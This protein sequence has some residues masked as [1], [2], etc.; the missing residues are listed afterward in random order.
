MLSKSFLKVM[1][2]VSSS[3]TISP[4]HCSSCFG[5][6]RVLLRQEFECI[7]VAL[8]DQT[9]VFFS[10]YLYHDVSLVPRPYPCFS[11]LHAEK[12]QRVT[13]KNTGKAWERGYH[14]VATELV[15]LVEVFF[16]A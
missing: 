2:Q 13:L 6:I 9:M 11:M 14:D 5:F 16:S 15:A 8:V 3:R 4:C 12:F 7:L 1:I 10:A